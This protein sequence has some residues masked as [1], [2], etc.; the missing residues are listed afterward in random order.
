MIPYQKEFAA[1]DIPVLTTTGFYDD[2]QIGALY[3]FVQH[4]RYRPNAE[5]YLLIGPYD[6]IRGQRGTYSRLGNPLTILRGYETDPLA[7]IDL[8]ELRYQW[9]DHIFKGAPKPPILQDKVN[10]EVMGA[11]TWKHAPTLAAMGDHTLRLHLSATRT[12]DDYRLSEKKPAGG[13]SIPQEVDLADRGDIERVI[14]GGS[15]VDKELNR[16]GSLVFTSDPFP[17]AAEVSG[18]FSGHLELVANKKD[19]DLSIEL[20]ELTAQGQYVE[21]SFFLSRAGYVRDRSHRRLLTPGRRERLNFQSGRLTSRRFQ[22]G[23]RLVALLRII[24]APGAQINYGTGKDVSD[25]TI[26]DAGEPL[27]IKWFSDSFIDV[28]VRR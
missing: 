18:L 8:G 15:I 21:L 11:N 22:P 20:Y 1:I 5:H 13:V 24:K 6:H 9:F 25:E 16:A 23:S 19:L 14:P 26:A 28:P 4:N 7:Q 10:Y 2:A 27:A 17:Q 12:G 3:Y